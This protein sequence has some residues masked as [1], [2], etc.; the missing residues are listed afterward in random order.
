MDL[1]LN[2]LTHCNDS[3]VECNPIEFQTLDFLSEILATEDWPNLCP[4]LQESFPGLSIGGWSQGKDFLRIDGQTSAVERGE[5]LKDFSAD[6]N[7]KLFL[8]SSVAGGMGINLVSANRIV[9]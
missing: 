2:I 8:I 9:L 5:L 7:L 6:K 4:S 3:I 1:L